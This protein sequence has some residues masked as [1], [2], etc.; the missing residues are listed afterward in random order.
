M[1]T[2]LRSQRTRHKTK[3]ADRRFIPGFLGTEGMLEQRTLLST[4]IPPT[5]VQPT[6][7]AA[8]EV[9][10]PYYYNSYMDVQAIGHGGSAA[11]YP[12]WGELEFN[13]PSPGLGTP[14]GVSDISSVSLQLNNLDA[15]GTTN[16]GAKDGTFSIYVIPDNT[17]PASS[18]YLT[19]SGNVGIA[20]LGIP[21]VTVTS[22]DLVGT[23]STTSLNTGYTTFTGSTSGS[24]SN[25]SA[26]VTGTSTADL[27]SDA[28]SW[29]K[30][31]INS[32]QNIRFAV[33]AD[34][35][36]FQTDW[37]G[38][39]SSNY[40]LLQLGV[41][42]APDINFQNAPYTV[43]EADQV[44]T[45]TTPLTFN[46]TRQGTSSDLSNP[47]TIHWA[48]ANSTCPAGG[49]TAQ[50][51]SVT[52]PANATT[53]PVTINFNDISTTQLTGVV[54]ITLSDPGGNTPAPVFYATTTTG[55]INYAQN[56]EL[57][58]SPTNVAVNESAGT[59]SLTVSRTGSAVATEA[60][61]VNY[62]T[63]NGTPY[64][65]SNDPTGQAAD[66]AQAGRD[67]TATSGTLSW[68]AG[69]STSRTITVPILPV[70]TFAT[71]TGLNAGAPPHHRPL[72]V[73]HGVAQQSKQ[74]HG[75]HRRPEHRDHHG[76]QRV[77]VR[78][79]LGGHPDHHE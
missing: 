71:T 18:M 19:A 75:D 34:D 76:Q 55:T 1:F 22:A 61:T 29:I 58:I 35:T 42:T 33:V 60:T 14:T 50:S 36:N 49:F 48:A 32:G 78:A 73:L 13:Y 25:N 12:S 24:T 7:G 65:A 31:H 54:N 21:G 37:E 41:T 10:G 6:Y 53:E 46:V 79:H 56:V 3:K 44:P 17:V 66:D 69:D 28:I 30:N 27:G 2:A 43:T 40:P 47:T 23:W 72:P 51:G 77:L 67:Y 68:A 59:V 45:H 15:P 9:G 70:E 5:A 63:A 52:F 26:H 74:R 39:Y 4:V 64:L 57:E 20:A 62:A 16:Y 38:N 11:A 8:P